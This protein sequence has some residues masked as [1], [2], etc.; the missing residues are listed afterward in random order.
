M[1]GVPT[2]AQSSD[3]SQPST[4]LSLESVKAQIQTTLPGTQIDQVRV[5]PLVNVYEV[6]AG[7]NVFY[8][9]PGKP[10]LVVGHLFDVQLQQD[11]TQPVLEQ[12]QT[13]QYHLTWQDLPSQGRITL[14]K[15][16]R[17]I[18]VFLDMDCPYCREAFTVLNQAIKTSHLTVQVYLL[19]LEGLH[20][21]TTAKSLAVLCSSDPAS[22]LTQAMTTTFTSEASAVCKSGATDTLKANAQFAEQHG[23]HG[24]PFF[25]TPDNTLLPGFDNRLVQWIQKDSPQ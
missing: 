22:A 15:G 7:S 6:V 9:Q 3:V 14:G 13:M 16:A 5:T 23:I 19:P 25:I 12:V 11:L 2:L 17:E 10:I 20:E 8:M 21:G 4:T 18:A 24:T 1:L